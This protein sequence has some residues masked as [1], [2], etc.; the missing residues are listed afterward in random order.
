MYYDEACTDK[1][2]LAGPL[3]RELHEGESNAVTIYLRNESK[4][5]VTNIDLVSDSDVIVKSVSSRRV[6]P[7]QV[8]KVV[9]EPS[10]ELNAKI[11]LG[12]DFNQ[13]NGGGMKLTYQVQ[14][15]VI[16]KVVPFEEVSV[17]GES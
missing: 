3:W 10:D 17:E 9:M 4:Y 8:A 15:R 5:D 14:P 12:M 7:G 11:T 13:L 2:V 1:V 6:G 16:P